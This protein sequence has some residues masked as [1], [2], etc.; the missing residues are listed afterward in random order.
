MYPTNS[1]MRNTLNRHPSNK[2]GKIHKES[3]P[4]SSL[5]HDTASSRSRADSGSMV[6]T[7]VLVKSRLLLYSSLGIVHGWST[8]KGKD[9]RD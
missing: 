2:R 6:K 1:N 5:S 9:F 4:F 8:S 3:I 7:Q